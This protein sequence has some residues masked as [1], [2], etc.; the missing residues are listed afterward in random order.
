MVRTLSPFAL[1]RYALLS[2]SLTE[3]TMTESLQSEIL[4]LLSDPDLHLEQSESVDEASSESDPD[5]SAV[6]L[7]SIRKAQETNELE[8]TPE[9]DA[10]VDSCLAFNSD[11]DWELMKTAL[12][13]ALNTPTSGSLKS[14]DLDLDEEMRRT[15]RESDGENAEEVESREGIFG[16]WN[17]D[18][19]ESSDEEIGLI[20][21]LKKI[22]SNNPDTSTGTGT[23]TV[24]G[25][26]EGERL[27]SDDLG[28]Q[29]ETANVDELVADLGN[30]S[31]NAVKG[32]DDKKF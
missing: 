4:A 23:S 10:F 21:D 12:L 1:D 22:L 15:E 29:T 18:I 17:L 8:F 3:G 32:W 30:L 20:K 5:V 27:N 31:L 24:S 7:E 28:E 9:D 11:N 2:L 14:P 6:L 19:E 25:T 16:I 26:A 13:E